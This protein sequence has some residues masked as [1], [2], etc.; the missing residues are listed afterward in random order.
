MYKRQTIN[1]LLQ[2]DALISVRSRSIALRP[3]DDVR[4]RLERS[5]WQFVAVGMPLLLVILVAGAILTTRRR[6]FGRA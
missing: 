3:L 6:M 2:E 4:I 1:Y 5:G